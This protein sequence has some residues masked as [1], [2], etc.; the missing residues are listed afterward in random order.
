[1]IQP[2]LPEIESIEKAGGVAIETTPDSDWVLVAFGRAWVSDSQ[3]GV[4]SFD[5]RTGRALGTVRLSRPCASM[6]EGFGSVWTL[7]CG[8]TGVARIDPVERKVTGRVD[9]PVGDD[10]EYSLGAGEGAVW[11]IADG[12][13]CMRC[14]VAR[15]DPETVK[16]TERFDVPRGAT[17]IRA[18]LGG[19][20]LT[21]FDLD[22]VLRV[23]PSTGEVVATIPVADGPRFLNV[24][25]GGVW[26]MAQKDG[27]AC[28]IDPAEDRLLGCTVVD[29]DGIFGGDISTGERFVWLRASN[30][31][32]A[33]IDPSTGEVVRRIGDPEASGGVGAGSGQLW[34]V[35]HAEVAPD[36]WVATLYRVPL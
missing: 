33:Q 13:D 3:E 19:L 16:V 21:Y 2:T 1:M 20:W 34:L 8:P 7:T 32:V 23:D 5:A 17:A 29:P 35:A 6:D 30:E 22:E 4:Y 12:D 28:H 36:Q 9:L 18:G 11:A 25:E 10:G 27:A 24:G 31:L 14:V 15:I 26:V